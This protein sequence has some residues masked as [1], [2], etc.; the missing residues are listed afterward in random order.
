MES[1]EYGML[2]PK[3]NEKREKIINKLIYILN[4]CAFI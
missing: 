1:S 4:V 2:T 3:A